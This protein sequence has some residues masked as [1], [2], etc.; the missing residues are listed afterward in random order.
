MLMEDSRYQ[1]L[2][3]QIKNVCP[4]YLKGLM[5][6]ASAAVAT[7]VTKLY[8]SYITILKSEIKAL[9]SEFLNTHNQI[10]A[11]EKG[12]LDQEFQKQIEQS[13]PQQPQETQEVEQE[14]SSKEDVVDS[15][16]STGNKRT[17][18]GRMK[19]P[20]TPVQPV[21]AAAEEEEVVEEEVGDDVEG[22]H[23]VKRSR[24]GSEVDDV[25]V[26]EETDPVVAKEV[27][28][29]MTQE[30]EVSEEPTKQESFTEEAVNPEQQ[31][32]KA[33]TPQPPSPQE[34]VDQD[35]ETEEEEAEQEQE[36]EQEQEHKP[37]PEE[38]TTSPTPAAATNPDS[39][40]PHPFF[41][42]SISFRPQL[43]VYMLT[44]SVFSRNSFS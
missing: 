3:Q 6:V 41:H 11:I 43:C 10:E 19:T 36:Q 20:S 30:E 13:Q 29:Q 40:G 32:Q 38:Q 25:A 21:A 4:L 33:P 28:E 24:V 18:G 8:V 34:I 7:L 26:Q 16:L 23:A 14:T 9:E 27:E 15:P 1:L 5:D 17:R 22:S 35:E 39:D 31:Q 2:Q 12:D 37:S 44:L 42:P